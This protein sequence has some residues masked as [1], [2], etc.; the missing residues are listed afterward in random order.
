MIVIELPPIAVAILTTGEPIRVTVTDDE[1]GTE[2]IEISV[3]KGRWQGGSLA[4]ALL[5]MLPFTGEKQ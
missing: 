5:E 4:T 2:T 1:G 3:Q